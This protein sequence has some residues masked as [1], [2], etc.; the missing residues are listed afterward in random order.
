MFFR[1]DSAQIRQF[2][3]S[4]GL[5]SLS[6]PFSSQ[7]QQFQKHIEFNAHLFW[8]HNVNKKP[9]T[10]YCGRYKNKE[11]AGNV[12]DSIRPL[13]HRAT[14]EKGNITDHISQPFIRQA[15]L[16]RPRETE[17]L[18]ST[19]LALMQHTIKSFP[20]FAYYSS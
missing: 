20:L 2:R 7:V 19:E 12:T 9:F 1:Y 3:A 11:T 13:A 6:L 18:E 8:L 4:M 5:P 17:T 10:R 15:L 14:Q 16:S